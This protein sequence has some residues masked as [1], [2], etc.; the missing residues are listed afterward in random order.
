MRDE[1]W[2][3]REWDRDVNG[4]AATRWSVEQAQWIMTHLGREIRLLRDG[5]P[6]R[7]VFPGYHG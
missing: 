6:L 4:G 1:K 3:R 7:R 5:V 2:L